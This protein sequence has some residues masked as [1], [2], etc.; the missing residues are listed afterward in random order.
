MTTYAECRVSGPLPRAA[1]EG[2]VMHSMFSISRSR[3]GDL[4]PGIV[5][6]PLDENDR[7]AR[8][9]G[10]RTCNGRLRTPMVGGGG[11]ER[12]FD[13]MRELLG[14]LARE[15]RVNADGRQGVLPLAGPLHAPRPYVERHMDDATGYF[16]MKISADGAVRL[17]MRPLKGDPFVTIE[18]AVHFILPPVSPYPSTYAFL[19]LLYDAIVADNKKLGALRGF[20]A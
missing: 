6:L 17:H 3:D 8:L 2:C 1:R 4:W 10:Y 14:V 9:P 13:V 5:R 7:D 18:R 19:P 15:S 16:G 20:H 11:T 12:I